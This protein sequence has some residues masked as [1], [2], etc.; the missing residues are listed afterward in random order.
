[1]TVVNH[2]RRPSKS[3][4]Y[5]K[6]IVTTIRDAKQFYPAEDYHQDYYKKES[7]HYEKDRALSGRDQFIT[8]HWEKKAFSD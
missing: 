5:I 3:G 1:M 8:E 6:P 7:E 2:T 4:R